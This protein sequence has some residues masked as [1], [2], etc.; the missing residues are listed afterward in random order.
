[1][2]SVI[3]D[4]TTQEGNVGLDVEMLIKSILSYKVLSASSET[5]SELFSK[6]IKRFRS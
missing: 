2:V 3:Y 5:L 6:M 1:M 4:I